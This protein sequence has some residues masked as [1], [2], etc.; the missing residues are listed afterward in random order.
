MNRL[1]GKS[2]RNCRDAFTLVELLVVIAIIGVLVALLLPAVQS[3]REAARRAQCANNLKQIGLGMLNYETTRK[4][5]PPG[6]YKPADIPEKNIMSWSVWHLPYIE[7]QNLFELIDFTEG[8]NEPPNNLPDFSGPTNTIIDTYLCP[9]TG[10]LQ[11]FRG[12]DHR[13]TDLPS[14]TTNNGLACMDYMGIPGP[15]VEDVVNKANGKPYGLLRGGLSDYESG[16][17]VK[18]L[19]R[20]GTDTPC[21][22]PSWEC[23]SKKVKAREVSDG[24]SYTI[25]VGESS[26]KAAE[27]DFNDEP[28]EENTYSTKQMS[29]AWASGRNISGIDLDP[30]NGDPSA[31]NPPEKY[32]FH[33]EDFFSDHP[34]GV[35]TLRCDG[36]V[37]FMTDETERDVYFALC[38]RDGG[39]LIPSE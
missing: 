18:T 35:Q 20:V 21:V 37:H 26:G 23:S 2:P 39:E 36:S 4:H 24:T 16:I 25:M 17:L 30:D 32:H 10:R 8:L 7:Q 31:I 38:S 29:G 27:E 15:D 34:G 14:N 1:L 28:G 5:F 12:D 9:S 22:I 6:R 13:I 11:R 19:V 3:A 33:Y